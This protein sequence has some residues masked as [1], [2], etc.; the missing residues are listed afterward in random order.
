MTDTLSVPRIVITA[1]APEQIRAVYPL[2]QQ[3]DST[4]SLSRW[5]RHARRVAAKP[6]EGGE[7]VLVASRSGGATLCGAVCYRREPT[8]SDGPVLTAE[9]FIA[10]DYFDPGAVF[11]ALLAELEAVARR[12]RCSAVRSIVHG[13]WSGQMAAF[14]GAGHVSEAVILT[15]QV[16][17]AAGVTVATGGGVR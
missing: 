3:A 5:L 1:L 10:M 6:G 15:K 16:A 12:S 11:R 4:L 9:H 7:G 2:M 14:T 8:I 17:P 13:K